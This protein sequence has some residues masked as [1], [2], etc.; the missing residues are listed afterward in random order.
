M[1]LTDSFENFLTELKQK[2]E[3]AKTTGMSESQ[4]TNQAAKVGDWLSKYYDPKSPEQR[5]LKELWDVSSESEQK[6]I[7][8][9]LYKL[10]ERKVPA[11]R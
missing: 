3:V 10:V 5:L 2:I 6:A 4:I 7:A 11:T 8:S 9:A 1:T